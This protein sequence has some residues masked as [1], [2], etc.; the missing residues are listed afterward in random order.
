MPRFPSGRPLLLGP[1]FEPANVTPS[2]SSTSSTP[3]LYSHMLRRSRDTQAGHPQTVLA[4]LPHSTIALGPRAGWGREAHRASVHSETLALLMPILPGR[5][6]AQW[7]PCVLRSGETETGSKRARLQ[8]VS[9]SLDASDELRRSGRAENPAPLRQGPAA[10]RLDNQR[11]PPWRHFV[12]RK[13]TSPVCRRENK[14]PRLPLCIFRE[15]NC[16]PLGPRFL[17]TIFVHFG[18]G[19]VTQ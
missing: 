8:I 9:N 12:W 5:P 2:S 11:A 3:S 7:G 14:N 13:I 16:H 1:G 4:H 19:E 6:K 10:R 18:R 15:L 17:P